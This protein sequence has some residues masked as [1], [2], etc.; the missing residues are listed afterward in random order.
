M[1][2]VQ[3]VGESGLTIIPG[4]Y[5]ITRDLLPNLS[6]VL[7]VSSLDHAGRGRLCDSTAQSGRVLG[8]EC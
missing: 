3:K 2:I 1:N 7:L 4:T 6:D 8:C 5:V